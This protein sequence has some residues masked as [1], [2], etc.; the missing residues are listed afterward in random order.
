V[1]ALGADAGALAAL[2]GEGIGGRAL[3]LRHR[4]QACSRRA[5]TV[6][7]GC[8]ELPMTK[9]RWMA[10]NTYCRELSRWRRKELR[11]LPP[12]RGMNLI[13]DVDDA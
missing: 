9:S 11:G 6:W 3:A 10:G 7:L 2:G 8:S 4:R 13:E 5:G 1:V 12:C